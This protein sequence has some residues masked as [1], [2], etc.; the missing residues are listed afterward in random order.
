M[1]PLRVKWLILT[2][3]GVVLL[4]I[5]GNHHARWQSSLLDTLPHDVNPAHQAY[6]VSQ[7]PNE[8]HV[9]LWI[10]VPLRQADALHQQLIEQVLPAL[11]AATPSI[12]PNSQLSLEPLLD[13]YR[14][15]A[16]FY[17]TDESLARLEHS[18]EQLINAAQRRLQQ[19]SPIWVDIERDPL[20]L[21]QEYVESLPDLLKGFHY[22]AP[23]YTRGR[24]QRREFLL[25]LTSG[26]DALS[27]TQSQYLVGV[28]ESQLSEL[29][30][31]FPEVEVARSG[32]LFH[33]SA[34][35]SQ[36][37]SEMSLFGS[38][39]IGFVVI[40]LIWVFRS[41]RHLLFTLSVLSAS[42]FLGLTAVLVVFPEPHVLMLV[43]AT[44]LIGLC[45][46]YVFHACIAASHG[47]KSWHHL[48]PALWLGGLTT[49]VGYMLLILLPL[50]LLQ[51]LGVFMAG[52][53][54]TVLTLVVCLIPRWR[55]QRQPIPVWQNMH[56]K[57]AAGY[58]R[59]QYPWATS[60][61]VAIALVSSIFTITQ[62]RSD[63]S[64][65]QLASSPQSLLE[66]EQHVRQI[67]QAYFDADVLLII[68]A[69]ETELLTSYLRVAE[70]LPQWQDQGLIARWQ[71]LFDYIEPTTKQKRTQA[72]LADLWQSKQGQDYL[73]WLGLTAPVYLENVAPINTHPLFDLFVYA[74]PK[75]NEYTRYLGVVRLAGV[76][77][78]EVF[79]QELAA[80][81]NVELY[82]PLHQ[83]SEALAH[84]R[85]QL[86]SWLLGLLALAWLV[87]SFRLRA[88]LHWLDRV[89]LSTQVIAVIVIALSLT[90][91]IAMQ[92]Y[93]LNVF[94]WVGAILV[95]VLGLDYGIFCAS[96]VHRPH[97]LQAISL[98]ALTTM[99]AFGVLSF[100]STPAIAAFGQVVWWGVLVCA[101]LAPFIQ[102]TKPHNDN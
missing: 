76:T 78:R 22:Q 70:Q 20:L 64:V 58:Q 101:L 100:S 3:I 55:I 19:P 56:A 21:T 48:I 38:L 92:S 99:I 16:G 85:Q 30:A 96:D 18:P 73:N 31:D 39:S 14:G 67:T 33:A 88:N 87:L 5:Y 4:F 90:L 7:Q 60:A 69:T 49:I 102:Q 46:D 75:H 13:F 77:Q 71:S 32:L 94:H 63:D 61:L 74:L 53:L 8:Q 62:Y 50:P 29:I 44:T 26:A 84:Y 15:R 35:A 82:N 2:A 68:G 66:Q 52:A 37:I 91:Y 24:E 9:L 95:L 1:R 34:A 45:I 47:P 57:I 59:L 25:A 72:A 81:P 10:S 51:Q 36:A 43:F 23:M 80:Y 97:I 12:T 93:P 40:M 86:E 17:V 79:M 65:Q 83:A 28:V 98:S 27:Q 41:M 42:G 54:L 11:A 89:K 6:Q